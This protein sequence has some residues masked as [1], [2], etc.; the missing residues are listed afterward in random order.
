MRSLMSLLALAVAVV[1]IGCASSQ[2]TAEVSAG[3]MDPCNGCGEVCPKACADACGDAA[4]GAVGEADCSG[5]PFSGKSEC[6]DAAPGAVSDCSA[7][8][9]CSASPGAVSD[10]AAKS[11]CS[12]KI[13]G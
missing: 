2:D 5:C 13:D 7:K 11:G 1:M 6:S 9:E 8:S 4:P 3:A 12:G 10:C